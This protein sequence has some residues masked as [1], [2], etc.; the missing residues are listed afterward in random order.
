MTTA[1]VKIRVQLGQVEL[2]YEGEAGFIDTK[3]LDMLEKLQS[4]VAKQP[5]ASSSTHRQ[6]HTGHG[7]APPSPSGNITTK[8]IA[9]K[10]SASSGS[11]VAKA[12]ATRLGIISG[13]TS[14]SRAD[15]LAEMKNATGFYKKTMTN[16]LTNSLKSLLEDGTLN[17]IGTDIYTLT[18][19]AEA[20]LRS[21]LG[22][23]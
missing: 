6:Q 2:D 10:L 12:A 11:D 21:T 20:T 1:T 16:N 14:F 7:A 18:P 5:D 17:E 4:M 13:R 8:T 15:I 19:R 9:T 3:L 22:A 23:A